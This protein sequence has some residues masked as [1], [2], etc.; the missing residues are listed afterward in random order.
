MGATVIAYWP[1]IT[2]EQLDGQP[3]FRNDDRGWGNWMA[4]RDGEPEV[5]QAVVDLGAAA[6]LTEM[7][8]GWDDDDVAWVTPQELRKAAQR[9]RH[10]VEQD[11]PGTRR[12]LAVYARHAHPGEPVAQQFLT[13]LADVEALSRW[14]EFH[15]TDRMTLQVTW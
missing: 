8:D 5:R 10:A 13:D 12:L 3:G 6:I 15:G 14:A 4:E 7:T 2:E 9:L 1:G 11:H